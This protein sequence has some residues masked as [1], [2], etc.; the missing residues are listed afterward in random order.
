MTLN[1]LM[2]Q[3]EP[4]SRLEIRY[5]DELLILTH[6]MRMSLLHPNALALT[7]AQ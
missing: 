6:A 7:P 4:S 1:S 3:E 2:S 5:T